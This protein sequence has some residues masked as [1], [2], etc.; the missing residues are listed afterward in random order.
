MKIMR[1]GQNN[2]QDVE[3]AFEIIYRQED[4]AVYRIFNNDPQRS[5]T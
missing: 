3:A 1:V 4:K 5:Q 2:Q